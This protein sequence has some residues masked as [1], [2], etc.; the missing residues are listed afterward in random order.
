MGYY[1]ESS[2]GYYPE[3]TK[4]IRLESNARYQWDEVSAPYGVKLGKNE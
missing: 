2:A 4:E 3:S 1:P